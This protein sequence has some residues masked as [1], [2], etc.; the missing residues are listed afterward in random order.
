MPSLRSDGVLLEL[1]QGVSI[2]TLGLEGEAVVHDEVATTR[3]LAFTA[4]LFEEALSEHAFETLRTI[5]ISDTRESFDM[6]GGQ[7]TPKYDED[8][9]VLELSTPNA[10]YRQVVLLQDEAG[11]I[12]WNFAERPEALPSGLVRGGVAQTFVLRRYVPATPEPG[13]RRGLVAAIGTKVIKVLAFPIHEIAGEVATAFAQKWETSNRPYGLRA[14]NVQSYGVERGGTAPDATM[15]A[16]FDGKPV[17]LLVHGTF[18][19]SPSTYGMLPAV[20][21]EALWTAYEGRVLAFDHPTMTQTP[22]QNAEWLLQ[23]VPQEGDFIFDVLTHSRG[24]LV[25]RTIAEKAADLTPR[26]NLSIRTLVLTAVPDNGTALSDGQYM[27]DFIDT[28]TNLLNFFPDSV[29]F[30]VFNCILVAVKEIAVG[31]LEHLSGLQSM[32]PKGNFQRWLN[33][34]PKGRSRYYAIGSAF[35]PSEPGLVEWAK[36]RLMDTIFKECN[37]MVVPTEGVY[38]KNGSGFFPIVSDD[39]LIF[40]EHDGVWHC[41]YFAQPRVHAKLKS[42][43]T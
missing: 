36:K 5:E 1:V 11:V 42:W 31:A 16:E 17:L 24:G 40:G 6:R 28:Y 15:W 20:L 33:E 29:P 32:I 13:A 2:S 19:T 18:S 27:G 38:R 9:M 26:R 43:L 37:D 25:A 41:N 39:R 10:N 3:A 22:R 35:S 12:T 30:D 34:G 7:R 23:Q 8:A 14:V 21:F 4:P